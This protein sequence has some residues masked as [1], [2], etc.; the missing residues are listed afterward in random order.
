MVFIELQRDLWGF[1][2]VTTGNQGASHVAPGQSSLHS[3]CEGERGIALES[4]QG[5]RASRFVEGGI[6]TS[7]SSC[8]RKPWVP[9]TCFGDL[10]EPLM[11]PMGSQEYCGVGMG[12]PG[13][14][15]GRGKVRGPH[16][17][18]RWGPQASSPVLTW[19]CMPS[20]KGSQ[21]STCVETWNSTFLWSCQKCFRPP[22]ELNLGLFSN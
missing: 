20:Q 7:F 16:L 22:G 2:R 18:L 9:S 1:S 5:N 15:W 11:A 14:N 17:K 6:S 8:R 10:T 12:L 19:L 3:S 4:W 21:V 13:L